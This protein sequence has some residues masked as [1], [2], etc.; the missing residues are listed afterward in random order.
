MPKLGAWREQLD[1]LL[2]AN[3]VKPARERLT[4]MRVFETLRDLGFDGGYDA[5]RRY[6]KSWRK[7]RGAM[8][9]QAY[10][11]LTFAP[12]EA[13]QFDWSHEVVLIDGVTIKVKVATCGC[14]IAACCSCE[15]IL[16]RARRW[17]STPTT[18]RSP[19]SR[20]PAPAASKVSV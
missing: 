18:G 6:A 13:Y 20:A 3:E 9:A 19:S 11:P 7:A 5:V 12:G 8:A 4:L 17:C 10:I 16:A 2:A 15:P 14:A 1:G